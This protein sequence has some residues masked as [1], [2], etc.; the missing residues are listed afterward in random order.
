MWQ[1][2][3]S[4]KN[5]L[6][7]WPGTVYLFQ[8]AVSL[9]HYRRQILDSSKLKEIADDN[10]KRRKWK[11]AIQT[12][13]KHCGGKGEII[14]YE[15]FLLFLQCFQNACFPGVSKGVIVWEWVK[16]ENSL[17]RRQE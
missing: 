10:F 4:E 6:P 2:L 16:G 14:R 11:K 7:L 15:Q 3:T 5:D 1:K 8:N 13:R 12:G 17:I 9:T